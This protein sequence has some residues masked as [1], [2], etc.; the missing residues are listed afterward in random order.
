MTKTI[1]IIALLCFAIW[2]GGLLK[3]NGR[4]ENE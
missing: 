1:I 2:L 4:D 3:A